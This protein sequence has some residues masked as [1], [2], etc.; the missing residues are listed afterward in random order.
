MDHF[1]SDW[2]LLVVAPS[3]LRMVWR[4]QALQWLSIGEDQ[5]QV[6]LQGKQ[7]LSCLSFQHVLS[8]EP[9]ILHCEGV[10]TVILWNR[11]TFPPKETQ[12]RCK[13]GDY[14]I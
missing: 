4:D 12:G 5:V 3:A 1:R 10:F 7:I 14:F 8:N 13:A 11:C 6:I 9:S 2:P